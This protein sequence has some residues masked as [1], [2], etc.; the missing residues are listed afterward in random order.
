M[1]E[2]GSCG[3]SRDPA[4]GRAGSQAGSRDRLT[5]RTF[6]RFIDQEKG[7]YSQFLAAKGFGELYLEGDALS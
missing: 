6:L 2:T 4:L 3:A 5:S 7:N 1:P